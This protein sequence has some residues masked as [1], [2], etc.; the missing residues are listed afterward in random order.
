MI[1][2]WTGAGRRRLALPGWIVA[3]AAMIL[4]GRA[5][6]QRTPTQYDVEAAYLVRFTEF[7][8][9]PPELASAPSL[10]ICVLGDD[11]FWNTLK[12]LSKNESAGRQPIRARSTQTVDDLKGC[13]IVFL[14]S[15]ESSQMDEDLKRLEG[16]DLLTVSDIPGFLERGGMIQF[17]LEQDHVRFAINMEAVSRTRI[18]VSSELIKVARNVMGGPGGGGTP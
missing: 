13:A 16:R 17:L 8:R 11:P 7:V 12:K 6:A 3:A 14:S 4:P 9:F 1:R 10:N 5:V 18:V 15:S 2:R